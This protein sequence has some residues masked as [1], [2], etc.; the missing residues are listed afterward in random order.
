[1]IISTK[2]TGTK[3][4]DRNLLIYANNS[5]NNLVKENTYLSIMDKKKLLNSKTKILTDNNC[6]LDFLNAEAGMEWRKNYIN[7]FILNRE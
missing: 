5:N 6:P 2:I 4:E 1:M 7:Y 3:K